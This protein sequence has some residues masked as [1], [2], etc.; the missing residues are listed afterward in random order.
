MTKKAETIRIPS[1]LK[2]INCHKPAGEHQSQTLHCP[3]GLKGRI[4]YTRFSTTVRFAPVLP[5]LPKSLKEAIDKVR[6]ASEAS[7]RA[8]YC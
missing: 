4:G 8:V 7:V 3:Q 1:A 5:H 6:R 2:C